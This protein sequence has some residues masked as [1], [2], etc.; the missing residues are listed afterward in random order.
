VLTKIG[1]GGQVVVFGAPNV[2]TKFGASMV[3][4]EYK[5]QALAEIDFTALAAMPALVEDSLPTP[6][7]N[8]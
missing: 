8:D 4:K 7:Q 5:A 1:Q 2:K 3:Y 6:R